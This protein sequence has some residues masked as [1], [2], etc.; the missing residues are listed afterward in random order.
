M[1]TNGKTVNGTDGNDFLRGGWLDDLIQAGAGND[2]IFARSGNDT[3]DAGDGNDVVFAGSGDDLV[4]TGPGRD[5]A[6]GG[7]GIDTAQFDG[8]SSDYRIT[9][10]FGLTFV[11]DLRNGETDTLTR[12]EFLKFDDG[13][14]DTAGNPI[15]T[16][17]DPEAVDDVAITNE[18]APISI[19]VLAN[20]S[21]PDNDPLTIIE[22]TAG[23]GSVEIDTNGTLIYTPDENF[24]G[25]DTISYTI[26][27]G[28]GGTSSA[29]VTVQVG[30]VADAPSLMAPKSFE[31]LDL[32]EIVLADLV[33]NLVD[34]D[35]SERLKLKFDNLP[36]GAVIL[37]KEAIADKEA[38]IERLETQIA[39]L[40]SQIE[41][42]DGRIAELGGQITDLQDNDPTSPQ[43]PLLEEQKAD[44]ED[45]TRDASESKSEAEAELALTELEKSELSQTAGPDGM[46]EFDDLGSGYVLQLPPGTTKDFVLEV[47]AIATESDPVASEDVRM[48]EST[49]KIDIAVKESPSLKDDEA[50]TKEDTPVT[51]NVLQ[52]D[53]DSD[54]DNLTISDVTD[55]ANG[56]VVINDDGTVT[57][58]PNAN[59]S[60]EDKFTYTVD[61]G[62]GGV[63]TATVKV[64]VG[65]VADEPEFSVPLSYEVRD[66]ADTPLDGLV[67][68]LTDQDGSEKLTVKFSRLPSDAVIFNAPAIAEKDAAISDLDRQITSLGIDIDAYNGDIAALSAQIERL[69]RED[70]DSEDLSGLRE[71]KAEFQKLVEEKS[72]A[73]ALAEQQRDQL[74]F[75][76]TQLTKEADEN[77][78]IEFHDLETG[79]VLR[80]PEGTK[81]DFFLG[82]EVFATEI[83]IVLDENDRTEIKRDLPLIYVL[84]SPEAGDDTAVTDEDTPV[85]IDV[86]GNDTDSDG[87]ALTVIDVIG[88]SDGFTVVNDDNTITF[89]P[90]PDFSGETEFTYTITDGNGGISSAVVKV[91]VGAVADLPNL[92]VPDTLST[93]DLAPISLDSID[94]SL[95]DTDGSESLKVNF[96]G[97]PQGTVISKPVELAEKTQQIETLKGDIERLNE[98]LV[99]ADEELDLIEARLQNPDATPEERAQLEAR[100]EAVEAQRAEAK[101]NREEA[102]ASRAQLIDEV[103]QLSKET[104]ANGNIEIDD[105]GDGYV[106]ILPKGSVDDFLVKVDAIAIESDPVTGEPLGRAIASAPI[107]VSVLETLAPQDDQASTSE[108]N[109]VTI[110]ATSN[111]V[112]EQPKI[113][114]V[115]D[116]ENGTASI[117]ANGDLLYTPDLNFSGIDTFEYTVEDSFGVTETATV[118]VTVGGVADK[119]SL[120][121]PKDLKTNDLAPIRLDGIDASLADTDGS[122]SLK[123]KFSGLPEGSIISS[124][125]RIGAVT[126]Q[127]KVAE[128][129]IERNFDQTAQFEARLAEINLAIEDLSSLT[130]PTQEQRDELAALEQGKLDL[131]SDI[132]NLADRLP[133]Q[134][135]RREKLLDDLEEL[136]QEAGSD[137]LIEIEDFG[138]GFNLQLPD[139]TTRNFDLQ[140]EAIATESEPVA[141]DAGSAASDPATIVISVQESPQAVDDAF[142]ATEDVPA[143]FFVVG[144]DFDSDNN[145]LTVTEVTQGTNGSVVNNDDG[146]VTYTPNPDFSGEDSFTY[147]IEDGT[148]G[149]SPST[150]TVNVMVGGVADRPAFNLPEGLR[151]LDLAPIDMDGV[152]AELV[153]Q[154]GSEVLTLKFTDLPEGSIVSNPDAIAPLQLLIGEKEALIK[155]LREDVQT[156]SAL[157]AGKE[158]EI[159]EELNKPEEEQ[160]EELIN[161][162]KFEVKGL[163]QQIAQDQGVIADATGAVAEASQRL[164]ELTQEASDD[165]MVSF[166]GLGSGF[167]LQLPPGTTENFVLGVEATATESNPVADE[168]D[169]TATVSSRVGVSVL[170]SSVAQD[171]T[172]RT[173]ED[174]AVAIDVLDNDLGDSGAPV[175]VVDASDPANG[176]VQISWDGVVS[177]TP[178]ANFNGTDSFTYTINDEVAGQSTA[179]VNVTVDPVNDD[180]DGIPIVSGTPEVG[181][182]L[183]ADVTGVSDPDT[184]VGDLTYQWESSTDGFNWDPIIGASN[185]TFSP[186]ADLIGATLQVRIFYTDGGS[187]FENVASAPTVAVTSANQDPVATDDNITTAEG[188]G[189]FVDVLGNDGDPD[190]DPLT[191]ESVGLASNGTT[192]IT[193]LLGG[194][195]MVSYAPNPGFSGAD[196]FTYEI[197]DGNGGTATG[198]VNVQVEPNENEFPPGGGGGGDDGGGGG[199]EP[200]GGGGG[201]PPGDGGGPTPF[202]PGGG[203]G[204]VIIVPTPTLPPGGGIPPVTIIA[205]TQSEPTVETG[206]V[207]DT[208]IGTPDSDVFTFAQ[209][210]DAVDIVGF[211]QAG[212][213]ADQIA[214]SGFG[215]NFGDLDSNDDGQV[216]AADTGVSGGG[217]TPLALNFSSG[218]LLTVD[219][220]SFLTEDDF[221]FV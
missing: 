180:P 63:S 9:S 102:S 86:L 210:D 200:P 81:E 129:D 212:E 74:K 41:W 35:G 156:N 135:A 179:T 79:Y 176:S 53:A 73:K 132:Q 3:V 44:L 163:Q 14:F 147:T 201:F 26:S 37:N 88:V 114:S 136:S 112:G 40:R 188:I 195:P 110:F 68:R 124:P 24:S 38:E 27:D 155:D 49:A 206:P 2:L 100:K 173:N 193:P 153:D 217:S 4:K 181:Q 80:L 177:Y 8:D 161:L 91:Q 158:R 21:D 64:L 116:S 84:E 192:S 166:D 190:G 191:L 157:V 205:S 108:D 85:T 96:R 209:G 57:Y 202:P 137:G 143:T 160:D 183:T 219:G 159:F 175:S 23:N 31:T 34:R 115:D 131:E 130:D 5:F 67:A 92:S 174:T 165:G 139:G 78:E 101:A 187:T 15:D 146:T 186:T 214:F 145:P 58:T 150:A 75:E 152:V 144:N 185:P 184:I 197:S 113:L 42:L 18:D 111:D 82:V 93:T 126:G 106:L 168:S 182:T 196:S 142:S 194:S 211:Q 171:D 94:A 62:N 89:T 215:L 125:A 107:Q 90:N 25:E 46:V 32:A 98:Q 7:R 167:V 50:E 105:F 87:D 6:D 97:L 208:Q 55:G 65:G 213:A 203:G 218:D 13:L 33:A 199:K 76:K 149:S 151:A 83:G 59:S 189:R 128:A 61:D 12:F 1:A 164:A 47:Q 169:R 109:P 69:L 172:A 207:T 72:A 121:A 221:L 16:N 162:L 39:D 56:K 122:E 220:V 140:V 141:G 17:D 60:G 103:D 11:T 48:A 154:D 66:G 99:E 95:N 120:S 70:P 30:G 134:V 148:D 133:E 123:V 28:N 36:E 104:D 71:Q 10:F 117:D 138:A 118:Q 204:G 119:P 216:D 127:L 198:T 51:I 43:I 22:A 178:D 20:D 45:Q 77:G 170:E 54:G 19:D 52:N 29:T